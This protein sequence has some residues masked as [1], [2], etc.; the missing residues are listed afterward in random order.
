M[1]LIT[2]NDVIFI[3]HRRVEPEGCSHFV[4]ELNLAEFIGFYG[5]EN[6][7]INARFKHLNMRGWF[8]IINVAE[9]RNVNEEQIRAMQSPSFSGGV[10][11][12]NGE[13]VPFDS[14]KHQGRRTTI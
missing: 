12:N 10:M 2:V 1:L 9:L 6:D 8:E 3:E 13:I 14:Y 4:T 5:K 7:T 11:L